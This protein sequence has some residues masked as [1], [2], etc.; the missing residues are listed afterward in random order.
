MLS[1]QFETAHHAPISSGKFLDD[2]GFLGAMP[3][4]K[5]I[6]EGTYVY[7]PGMDKHTH[8][9]MEEAARLF[10]KNSRGCASNLCHY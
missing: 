10:V 5:E 8:L 1:D 2:I 9:L 4:V 7:P 6:P 3:A